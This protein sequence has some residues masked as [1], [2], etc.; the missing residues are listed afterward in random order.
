MEFIYF[1]RISHYYFFVI[2]SSVTILGNDGRKIYQLGDL[3]KANKFPLFSFTVTNLLYEN[4]YL[5]INR[6]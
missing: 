3:V 2:Y 6:L 1:Y 4:A 5:E